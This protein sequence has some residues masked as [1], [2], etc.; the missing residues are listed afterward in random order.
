MLVGS[1]IVSLR[2]LRRIGCVGDD[3]MGE[4]LIGRA[5]K[6]VTARQDRRKVVA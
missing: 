5:M 4:Y 3:L 6:L 2:R 1:R